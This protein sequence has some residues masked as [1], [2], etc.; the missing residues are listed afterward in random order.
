MDTGR[1][2]DE[3]RLFAIQGH[4]DNFYAGVTP[5]GCQ[6]LMSV[7][8]PNIVAYFFSPDGV[9]LGQE[10]RPLEVEPPGEPSKWITLKALTVLKRVEAAA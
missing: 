5:D 8:G 9:L 3:D 1:S 10:K 4:S 6:V 2:E 7:N